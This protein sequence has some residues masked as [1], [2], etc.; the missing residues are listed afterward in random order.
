MIPG[1]IIFRFIDLIDILLVAFLM[2]QIYI[3]IKDTLAIH[4][5]VAIIAILLL[6]K[7]VDITKMKLLGSIL[8]QIIGVGAIA[9]IVLFQQEIR[10]FLVLMG[11]RYFSNYR[12]NLDNLFLTNLKQDHVV[13]I[14]SI[15]KACINMAKNKTGALIVLKKK[16][17]LNTYVESG[18]FINASTSSRLI[19]SIFNKYGPLHDGA[20]I[21]IDDRIV[22]ARCVLPVSDNF[23]LPPT[24]GMRHRAG[25]GL[26]EQ[27]DSL[28]I[29]IS[30]ETGEIS[31]AERG[32]IKRVDSKILYRSL[33]KEFGIKQ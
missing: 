32:K 22:A 7:V 24:Y 19:E 23:N 10:R 15:V 2:Y 14:N 11:T 5:F 29:I 20:V 18:D 12:L 13:K 4:I 31:L 3:L 16:S 1:F 28:V 30:E 9:I 6:W 27:T 33:E 21:I 26:T 8:G 25:I 17:H